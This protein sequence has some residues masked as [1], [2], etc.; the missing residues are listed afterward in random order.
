MESKYPL[1]KTGGRISARST[2]LWRTPFMLENKRHSNRKWYYTH[3]IYYVF[4]F[5]F[6]LVVFFRKRKAGDKR[7]IIGVIVLAIWQFCIPRVISRLQISWNISLTIGF[8]LFVVANIYEGNWG[9]KSFFVVIFDAIWM[10]VET[11]SW[12]F[13][14]FFTINN[15]RLPGYLVHLLQKSVSL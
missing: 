8:S 7:L 15:L 1:V 10:L 2:V 11:F 5:S 6:I 12:K 9:K 4:V 13:F 3:A 14:Y